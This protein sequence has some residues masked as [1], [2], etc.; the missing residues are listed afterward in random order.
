PKSQEKLLD[1]LD[2]AICELTHSLSLLEPADEDDDPMM[3]RLIASFIRTKIGKDDDLFEI[4]ASAVEEEMARV[5]DECD[6]SSYNELEKIAPHADFLLSSGSIGAGRKIGILN[7]LL[8]HYRRSARY[9]TSERYGR[10]AL[11]LSE[12]N[13]DPGHPSIAISQSNLAL[14]LQ[15]LGDLE[16]ARDLSYLA[17]RA[18]LEKFGPDHPGTITIKNNWEYIKRELQLRSE[19]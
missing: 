4:V 6:T 15:D 16:E 8:L 12:E 2:E 11:I 13:Y 17:Y 10:R 7:Y 1:S 14:V 18:Y 19:K 5:T 9:R 3:H